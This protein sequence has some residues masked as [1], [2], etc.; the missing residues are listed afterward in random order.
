MAPFADLGDFHQG[1]VE[2]LLQGQINQFNIPVGEEREHGQV[3][4][5]FSNKQKNFY[6][7][8]AW[9][10][11]ESIIVEVKFEGRLITNV[12]GANLDKIDAPVLEYFKDQPLR[13]TY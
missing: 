2:G 4:K 1:L 13:I 6:E 9:W 12:M 10:V 7:R 3:L 11:G 8:T 5:F